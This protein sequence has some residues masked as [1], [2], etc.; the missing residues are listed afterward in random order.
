[1]RVRA[2]AWYA[3]R[4]HR[5]DKGLYDAD[6]YVRLVKRNFD[7]IKAG[8]YWTSPK[9]RIT[10]A[11]AE[12]ADQVFAEWAHQVLLEEMDQEMVA[13]VPIPSSKT[14]N[15]RT[16]DFTAKRLAN[17]LAEIDPA[18]LVIPALEWAEPHD[19]LHRHRGFRTPEQLVPDLRCYHNRLPPGVRIVLVDDVVTSG[20]HLRA[21]GQVLERRV[22]LA[23]AVAKADED[24]PA[25]AFIVE[26]FDLLP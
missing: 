14:T 6:M 25:T 23:L 1:M 12:L 8:R 5:G 26:P 7:G 2:H 3:T 22:D 21:A 9:G 13:M 11:N 16:D 10:S 19:E 18:V 15:A 24:P 4:P 20:S 17:R